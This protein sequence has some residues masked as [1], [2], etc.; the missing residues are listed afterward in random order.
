[1]S[2]RSLNQNEDQVS[3]MSLHNTA[4]DNNNRCNNM[5]NN[6]HHHNNNNSSN[7]KHKQESKNFN[8]EE[9]LEDLRSSFTIHGLSRSVKGKKIESVFWT[10]CIVT[11]LICASL[12]INTLVKKFYSRAV[13]SEIRFQ[14]TDKNYF[15]R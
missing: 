3:L 6:N 8:I 9:K 10:T 5:N 11:G 13:Y 1:M 14:I 12:L 15:P 2:Q 4:D 7:Q